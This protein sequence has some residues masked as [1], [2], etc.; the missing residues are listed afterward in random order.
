MTS[1]KITGHSSD[2]T[3]RGLYI[4]GNFILGGTAV[5]KENGQYDVVI[6]PSRYITL[7][8]TTP[9]TNG[10]EVWIAKSTDSGV[11][12]NKGA[13]PECVRFLKSTVS[14][15]EVLYYNDRFTISEVTR[16]I[17]VNEQPA[18]QTALTQNKI[19]DI[20]RVRVGVTPSA[21]LYYQWYSNPTNSN[22]GGTPI[23]GAINSS[24][25]IPTTLTEGTYYYYCV[26]SAI[27]ARHV[28]T[29]VAEVVISASL[30][31]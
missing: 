20:L 6:M 21:S 23:T 2:L 19:D 30:A 10:M 25:T 7:S 27:N 9:P 17:T 4:D 29:D 26:V 12:V 1:G 22:S 5:I 15:K 14:G 18:T 31:E 11:I 24:F 3:Q 8:T 28:T 13:N 16:T